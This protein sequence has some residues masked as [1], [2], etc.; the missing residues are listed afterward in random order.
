[1]KAILVIRR[2]DEPEARTILIDTHPGKEITIG[3]SPQCDIPLND[4]KLSRIHCIITLQGERFYLQ[5]NDSTNGTFLNRRQLARQERLASG[6]VIK[7]GSTYIKFGWQPQ[8]ENSLLGS[9]S[10]IPTQIDKYKI[11][12]MIGGGGIGMVYQVRHL[13]TDQIYAMKILK[14]E[15]VEDSSL[16]SRFY[17]EARACS[18]LNHPALLKIHDIG[19]FEDTPY[20]VLDYIPGESLAAVIRREVRIDLH[21]SLIIA[22]QIVDAL[23]YCHSEGVVH[24]DIKPGNILIVPDNQAKLIDMGMV[25]MMRESGITVAGQAMGTP[26]YMPPEQIDDSSS[27]DHLVDIYGFGATLYFMIAGVP[28]Y[29]EFRSKHVTELLQYIINTP[30]RPIEEIVEIPTAIARM[31]A[32]AMARKPQDR[33]GSGQEFLQ[34]IRK[35]KQ[36]IN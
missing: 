15:A 35:V 18:R 6:D 11:V 7:L 5:D 19:F 31:I 23:T 2:K 24:R 25:K 29:N 10:A 17:Q 22:E 8:N 3:R 21:R 28:P 27:V 26:R 14:P 34:E 9:D 36:E 20:L 33:F 16:V 12:E 13:Q 1:M 30:P 4:P 32:K